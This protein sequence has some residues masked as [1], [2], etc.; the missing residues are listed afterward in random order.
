MSG[1]TRPRADLQVAS[2]PVRLYTALGPSGSRFE[3]TGVFCVVAYD[4]VGFYPGV[5]EMIGERKEITLI[6]PLAVVMRDDGSTAWSPRDWDPELLPPLE[7][8]W[9]SAHPEWPRLVTEHVTGE[10]RS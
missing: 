2:G 3:V 5:E 1:S 9:L 8:A 10:L 7:R 4:G 6:S